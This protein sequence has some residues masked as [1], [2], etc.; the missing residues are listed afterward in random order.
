M[1]KV[2]Q[3]QPNQVQTE[4]VQQPLASNAPA[5]TFGADIGKGL[6]DVAQATFNMKERIDTTSAEEAA[7][8]FERDKNDIFFNPDTG[9]FNTQGKNAYDQSIETTKSLEKLKK[10]Y[11]DT[12]NSNARN[13]FN[14][15]A[16][17]Q[18]TSANNDIARY[19]A[20]GLKVWEISTLE[21]QTENALENS[22]LYWDQ[23]D[24]LKIQNILGRQSIIESSKMT[25]ISSE[26]TNEKLQSFQSAF[27]T[28]IIT[29]ATQS[30][31]DDGEV[32]FKNYADE[33]EGPDKIKMTALIEKKR[34]V[35]KVKADAEMSLLTANKLVEQYDNLEDAIKEVK[36]IKD[37]ELQKKTLTETRV[38]FN[39]KKTFEKEKA[40]DAYQDIIG[41]VN[42][43]KTINMIQAESSESW[44]A[45]T[46][47]QRN[48]ILSGKHMIT[49]QVLLNKLRLL[50]DSEKAKLNPN[51]YS[52]ELKPADMNKLTTEIKA[53][54]KGQ[55]GSRVKSLASKSMIAAEG[56]FGK[57]SKWSKKS[58]GLTKKGEQANEFLNDLQ[59]AI[60]EWETDNKRRITPVE[61]NKIIAEFTGVIVAERSFLGID[62]LSGDDELDLTN[63]PAADIRLLNR[64][65]NA[66]PERVDQT[67]LVDAYQS[68]IEA[69]EPINGET[70]TK[71]YK[72]QRV[73]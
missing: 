46:D 19:A 35:E 47:K 27:A 3:Y 29:A 14:K 33:L 59:S 50:P 72:K 9:Y 70:L 15:V 44:L 17:R 13:L 60:D 21:S 10:K 20:K 56:I 12:L 7:V 11:A 69:G 54:K 28:N 30:S 39:I 40:N 24:K 8:Q 43:G 6:Q 53:A 34:Q 64:I 22:A 65:K 18:I 41:E 51:D 23:P 55:Q 62:I 49:N 1:P 16:Q 45:M 37:T 5:A 2:T 31:A 58:G 67:V 68:L 26:S 57:K 61:E 32:V 38:Q 66:F 71:A 36:K 52:D 48:N 25:G 42:D 4:V 73:K 63:T